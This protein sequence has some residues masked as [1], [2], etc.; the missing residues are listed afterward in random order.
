VP[1]FDA[2]C[3]ERFKIAEFETTFDE[4]WQGV[5]TSRYKPRQFVLETLSLPQSAASYLR[6]YGGLM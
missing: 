5:A 3:G 1:Y 4:F 2:R 6:L